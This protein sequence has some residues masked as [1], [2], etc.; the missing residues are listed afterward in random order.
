[1]PTAATEL[2]FSLFFSDKSSTTRPKEK[3]LA[4]LKQASAIAAEAFHFFARTKKRNKEIRRLP[5]RS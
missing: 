1:M 4:T 3:E 2:K 5:L